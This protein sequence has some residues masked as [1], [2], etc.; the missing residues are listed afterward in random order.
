MTVSE[1]KETVYDRYSKQL[2]DFGKRNGE[3]SLNKAIKE[4]LDI[5]INQAENVIMEAEIRSNSYNTH[6]IDVFKG[7]LKPMIRRMKKS[8]VRKILVDD[9]HEMTKLKQMLAG[10]MYIQDLEKRQKGRP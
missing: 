9:F 7:R 2:A 1:A 4:I 5:N 6:V 3:K 8:N 10:D